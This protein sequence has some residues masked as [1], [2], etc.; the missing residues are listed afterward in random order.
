MSEKN[1]KDG[2]RKGYDQLPIGEVAEARKEMFEVLGIS[3]NNRT[4][5]NNY[6][7]GKTE[8]KAT[9]AVGLEKVFQKRNI[10]SIWGK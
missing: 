5:F 7:T 1:Y 2:F 9:Q 6:L 8:P 4:S 10:T 3:E